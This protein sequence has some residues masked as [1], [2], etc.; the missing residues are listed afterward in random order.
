MKVKKA[1][2]IISAVG[3]GQ[4]PDGEQPEI[5]L[6]GRSN[7]GKSSLINKFVN[8]KNLA[9][10]SSRPGKTQAINF[11]HINEAWYFVDLPGYGFA[12]VSKE[13]KA[14]WGKFIN[15]Y[16]SSREQLAGLIQIVDLRHPPSADDVTMYEWVVAS[17]IP[18]L[19]VATKADKI[20]RGQ[21]Q[22][23]EMIIRKR[24]NASKDASV[25]LFSSISGSGSEELGGWLEKLLEEIN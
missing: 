9:R 16:L 10:T 24:L 1:E 7:V 13:Q 18:Y 5:A 6:L 8:R 23:H 21:W 20:S 17:G 4:Y 15:E 25:V 2:Y 11:Y 22:K 14:V 12:K 3:P 19:I